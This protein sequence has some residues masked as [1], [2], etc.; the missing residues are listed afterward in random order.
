MLDTW[1][2]VGAPTWTDWTDVYPRDEEA[3][4][5]A[6]VTQQGLFEKQLDKVS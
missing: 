4:Y 6:L 2:R 5:M 1:T 3:N